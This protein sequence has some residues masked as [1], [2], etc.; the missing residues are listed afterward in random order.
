MVLQERH[1][2]GDVF[3]A[4]DE[5]GGLFVVSLY[6]IVAQDLHKLN[7]QHPIR[8]VVLHRFNAQPSTG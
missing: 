8:H 3:D 4:V 2:Y 6:G 7:Q 1:R 5:H